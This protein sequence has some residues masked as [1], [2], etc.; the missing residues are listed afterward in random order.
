M[1]QMTL[2]QGRK[3]DADLGN[4]LMDTVGKGE[5]GADESSTDI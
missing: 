1:V 2:F 4:R 5:G 3:R